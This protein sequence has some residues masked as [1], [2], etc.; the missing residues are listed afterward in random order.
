MLPNG[1]IKI[2]S[3]S[4]NSDLFYATFGG[5]GLTG[6]IL[7]VAIK[8]KPIKTKNIMQ[9][10]IKTQN[11]KDTLEHLDACKN[12][13]Y[14]VAWIDSLATNKALGMGIVTYGDFSSDNE[15]EQSIIHY[16]ND[17]NCNH[18]TY[19]SHT[20][21]YDDIYEEGDYIKRNKINIPFYFPSA[22]LNYL[23]V[24]IFN[25]L[26]YA[27]AKVGSSKVSFERFFY[28][29]DS[30][31]NWNKVYGKKG[32]LQYQCIIPKESGYK[33]LYEILSVI[34][35]EKS[36]SFLNVLKLYGKEDSS[37]LCFPLEGYSLALD[38]KITNDVFELMDKLDEIVLKYGGRLYLA[39]DSRMSKEMFDK[40][41]KRANEFRTLRK[42][43]NMM[44][45]L[46]SLQGERLGI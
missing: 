26:Y 9:T 42:D 25:K 6:V 13:P 38:F 46:Q 4:C 19:I 44:G 21:Q 17:C 11:L 41:Y 30:I 14:A 10:T 5:V 24:S 36:A 27:R 43:Y 16:P 12:S 33:A 23:S 28:P 31:L 34:T 32:F 40:T 8:L 2:C 45:K 15:L 39:K 35:Q 18:T 20:N 7:Q 3:R 1:D 22:T 37:F 29:L